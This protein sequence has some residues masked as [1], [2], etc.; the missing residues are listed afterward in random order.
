MVF[1]FPN[2]VKPFYHIMSEYIIP[3]TTWLLAM[4]HKKSEK[5][6]FK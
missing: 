2:K 3:I 4:E 5:K 1:L 6:I